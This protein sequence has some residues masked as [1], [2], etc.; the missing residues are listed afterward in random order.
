LTTP[1]RTRIKNKIRKQMRSK[2]Q[3]ASMSA[4]ASPLNFSTK[5]PKS[6]K[7]MCQ[8]WRGSHQGHSSHSG[9]RSSYRAPRQPTTGASHC[10]RS[11]AGKTQKRTRA[12]MSLKVH[13]S[14]I[15]CYLV[16]MALQQIEMNARMTRT[17]VRKSKGTRHTQRPS[18]TT[19]PS[20]S[21]SSMTATTPTST[22]H[23][24]LD[25]LRMN[26]DQRPPRQTSSRN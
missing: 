25:H 5:T 12:S 20:C 15:I 10:T 1:A 22:L 16:E 11:K 23:P 18:L 14:P 9:H 2:T 19:A 7:W 4:T 3:T 24:P 6:L 26:A 17:P 8:S 21:G 13:S